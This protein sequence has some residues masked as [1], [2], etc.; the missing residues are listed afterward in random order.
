MIHRKCIESVGEFRLFSTAAAFSKIDRDF[1][2]LSCKENF[3]RTLLLRNL[4]PKPEFVRVACLINGN[5]HLDVG[6]FTFLLSS[7]EA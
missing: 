5:G 7:E 3:H 2:N 1:E 6:I 4:P